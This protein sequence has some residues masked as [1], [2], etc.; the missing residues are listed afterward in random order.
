LALLGR[1]KEGAPFPLDFGKK[2]SRKRHISYQSQKRGKARKSL[3]SQSTEKKEGHLFT[4]FKQEEKRRYFHRGNKGRRCRP[5]SMKKKGALFALSVIEKGRTTLAGGISTGE[6]RGPPEAGLKGGGG[7]F[8]M[9]LIR[10]QKKRL[11]YSVGGRGRK[12]GP[13]LTRVEKEE[14]QLF[15]S[16]L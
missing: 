11:V 2:R 9:P 7:K 12:K 15:H 16:L 6:R 13:F 14:T 4:S 8:S 10:P 3:P 1:G 5:S